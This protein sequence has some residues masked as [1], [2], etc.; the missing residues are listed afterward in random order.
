MRILHID[1]ELT[2]RGGQNQTRLL[3]EGLLNQ[4]CDV[5]L[6]APEN[7]ALLH[8]MSNT[9]PVLPLKLRSGF[10]WRAGKEIG[11]FCRSE[12]IDIMDAQSAKAHNLALIAK[13]YTKDS[14]LVVHRRVDYK[15]AN[16]PLN[17][18]KYKTRKVDRY[19]AISSAIGEVLRSFGIKDKKISV[20]KSAASSL[21][22][23]YASKSEAKLAIASRLSL[24]SGKVWVGSASALTEQ[25][26]IPTL[27]RAFGR[28]KKAETPFLGI[29]AG[30]GHL[31]KEL[32]RQAS[33]LGLSDEY[34][35]F[36]GFRDDVA[37]LL[38]GFDIFAISSQ[39]EG[40][41]TVIL[42]AYQA[43]C[44]VVGT[45]VGGIPEIIEHGRSGFLADRHDDDQFAQHLH[46]LIA[47]PSMRA[48]FADTGRRKIE[49]DF[50]I[51]QMIK[52]NMD[53]YREILI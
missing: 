2:W 53:V 34:V 51:E 12:L 49:T 38:Q 7:S 13:R 48:L 9:I 47:N 27:L 14:K 3:I 36:I 23:N 35:K 19:I 28:L 46:K 24:P 20:V 18:I 31:E 11:V 41:G 22:F 25:K 29:I 33:E 39:D 43:G 10:D 16:H 44:C 40:L 15:P 50:S 26:D 30:A 1:T 45:A 5:Y 4:S 6:A 42:D 17:W 32:K 21:Q 8:A 52:G 37:D